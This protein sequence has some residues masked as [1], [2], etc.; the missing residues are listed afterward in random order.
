MARFYFL[1]YQP[2]S[3]QDPQSP[4]HTGEPCNWHGTLASGCELQGHY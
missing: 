3:F 4:L 2:I 1:V